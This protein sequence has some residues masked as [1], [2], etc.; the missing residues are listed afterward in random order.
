M[1]S[2][3]PIVTPIQTNQ[4]LI[5]EMQQDIKGSLLGR[6]VMWLNKERKPAA[7]GAVK[8]LMAIETI[9][10]AIS[11]VGI[12]LIWKG[13]HKMERIQSLKRLE[14]SSST[15][16]APP[17]SAIEMKTKT[18]SFNHINDYCIH[19][20]AL[21]VRP[22]ENL[23]ADWQMIYFDETKNGAKPEELQVDG[24]NLMIL[25]SERVLHYKKVLLEKRDKQGNY[26]VTDMSRKDNWKA[27]WYSFPLLR[28][29]YHLFKKM[30]LKIPEDAKGW[31]MSHRGKYNLHF[32]DAMGRKHPEFAMVTTLYLLPKEGNFIYYADPYVM[33][34]FSRKFKGPGEHFKA[35]KIAA[36]ASM[37]LLQGVEDGK[38]VFYTRLADFDAIGKNP[39][40]PGFYSKKASA[41][42]TWARYEIPLE[43]GA[44]IEGSITI[45]QD[46]EGNNA[47]CLRIEGTNSQGNRGYYQKEISEEAWVFHVM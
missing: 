26:S 38:T 16:Q 15:P 24:A 31:A 45:F 30:R 39:F 8:A 2:P 22:R 29:F 11:L 13:M 19:D 43:P 47:R 36:S 1:S 25:D 33:R 12:P 42:K 20:G 23:D 9:L 34:G 35:Q 32:E 3:S 6:H 37:V 4:E 46:G 28:R 40:L 41:S 18:Q 27:A 7:A 17:K 5:A 10:A 14:K 44:T 21:W